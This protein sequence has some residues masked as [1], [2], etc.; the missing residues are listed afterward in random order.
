VDEAGLAAIIDID[1]DKEILFGDDISLD[2]IIWTGPMESLSDRA[3][4]AGITDV[5]SSNELHKFIEDIPAKEGSVHFLPPYRP[6][7]EQK[8]SF[9]LDIPDNAIDDQVSEPL[10]KSVV[11]QR[12]NKAP[13]EVEEIEKA[14][15]VTIDMQLRVGQLA[16]EGISETAIA[17]EIHGLTLSAGGDL[18]FPT[19]VTVNGQVLHN[20]PQDNILQSGQM[21]LCDC[22]AET[23]MHY[24]GDLTRTF[25]VN[26]T[27]SDRQRAIYN[28]IVNAHLSAIEALRPGIKFKDIHLL[29]CKKLTEGLK[30]IGLMKGDVDEA[31]SRGAHEMFF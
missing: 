14:I 31:V 2:D 6:E 7:H 10:I 3:I 8:L 24:A 22:G 13:E 4:R 25:P 5:R 20:Q 30:Q 29:A 16:K 23:S 17:G 11:N 15:N 12:S 27:F 28:I 26:N 9:L 18:A 21:L 19:I 1:H